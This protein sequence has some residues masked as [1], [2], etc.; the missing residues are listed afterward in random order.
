[1]YSPLPLVVVTVQCTLSLSKK[2]DYPTMNA[3]CSGCN[4]IHQNCVPA[5]HKDLTSTAELSSPD[6][7]QAQSQIISCQKFHL[8]TLELDFCHLRMI[9]GSLYPI[10]GNLCVEF[11]WCVFTFSPML[12]SPLVFVTVNL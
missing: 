3:R 8:E 9:N 1:M 7:H 10:K 11:N 6:Q 12:V 2:L 4:T 5:G